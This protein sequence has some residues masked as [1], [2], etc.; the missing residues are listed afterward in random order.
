[1]SFQ[2]DDM[3]HGRLCKLLLGHVFKYS[4][5]SSTASSNSIIKGKCRIQ[6]KDLYVLHEGGIVYQYS[7]S[8]GEIKD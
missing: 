5:P 6:W 7:S 8:R 2:S 4:T 1:M 3:K